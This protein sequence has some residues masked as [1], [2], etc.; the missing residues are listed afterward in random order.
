MRDFF[1]RGRVIALS[2]A[3]STVVGGAVL[4]GTGD[5][6]QD[7]RLLSGVAWFASAKVGQLTLLD[8]S[9][10]EVAA[11]VQVGPAG[12]ALEVVQ[13]GANAYAID[14]T[15]GTVRRIDG[16]TFDM[17]EPQA[18]IPDA[19]TG[20]TAI[21]GP[22]SLYTVDGSRGILADTDPR[23]LDR[24]GGL[25]SLANQLATGAAAVDDAGTLWAIDSTNGSLNRVAGGVR[26]IRPGVAAPGPGFVAITDG[27]PVVVDVGGRRAVMIDKSTGRPGATA[28]L[29]LRP[30]DTLQVSGSPRS[31]RLYLVTGRG[32]LVVCDLAAARCDGVVP[33]T[34]GDEYGAAVEASNKLFV[35]DYTTGQVLIVDLVSN[36]VLATPTVLSPG[37]K[38]QLMTRDG[39]VFYNDEVSE[40]AGVIQLDGSI[41]QIRKYNPDNPGQGVVTP[42]PS[43]GQGT[44][45]RPS[46]GSSNSPTTQPSP[47]TPAKPSGPSVP[48]PPPQ[49]EQHKLVVE[50]ATATVTV[51]E[52]ITLR[53]RGA[54]SEP[55]WEFGDGT[56]GG[57]VTTSHKWAASGAFMVTVRAQTPDGKEATASATVNVTA[58]QTFT[59][60]VAKPSGGTIKGEGVDCPAKTCSVKYE[61]DTQVTLHATPA[62]THSA[63]TWGGACAGAS[64]TCEV[65]MKGDRD[66]SYTFTEKDLQMQVVAQNGTVTLNGVACTNKTCTIPVKPRTPVSLSASP[67]GDIYEFDRWT[68]GCANT[69][70]SSCT[71]SWQSGGV[72]T[73]AFKE[74][75]YTLTV[76]ST[77]WG[78]VTIN[79]VDCTSICRSKRRPNETV[80]LKAVL[81][82]GGTFMGWSGGDCAN[83]GTLCPVTMNGQPK[84]EYARFQ[85]QGT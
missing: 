66:V 65:V 14:Q 24:R 17:T 64:T 20:L 82:N 44:P 43:P 78:Y 15:A 41:S 71:Q 75:P 18:P 72:I 63:G 28:D 45:Q 32:V 25:L 54:A 39:L 1:R 42:S 69:G 84:S 4:L 16:A 22:A 67:S 7:V 74:G 60:T 52:P 34:A 30:Q 35:P 11:Q 85:G 53:V 56:Q 19:R 62:S 8:G 48:A 49:N 33:L 77:D 6:G 83:R 57:G 21:P 9:S 80:E 29:D 61:V 58:K 38:F 70:V 36:R 79:G 59:L 13:Q 68:N 46:S 73:G 27:G 55:R 40:R 26:T 47:N 81:G 10:A 37:G 76:S 50:P 12:N 5:H 51:N 2:A 23:T 31:Q 3:A